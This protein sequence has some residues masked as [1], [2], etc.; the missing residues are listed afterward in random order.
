MAAFF[1]HKTMKLLRTTVLTLILYGLVYAQS[2]RPRLVLTANDARLIRENAGRYPM[3]DR[4]FNDVKAQIEKALAAPIDV[5]VPKDAGGYTHERHKQNYSEMYLAGLL[6]SVTGDERYARFIRDMLKKYADLYPT[7]GEHPARAGESSGRLFWQTLN[8]TVWLVH[9]SQAYDF[10][11]NWLKPEER[12]LFEKNIFRPMAKFFTVDRA[13]EHD[14]IHNHG[15]WMVTAVGMAG[16]AMRDQNLVDIALYGT[17]K[18]GSGGFLKQ[19]DVL[20]S[21]DGYY[22]EGLYYFRYAIMPFILFA[23]AIENNQPDLKIFER[24]GAILKKALYAG[25]QFTNMNGA[26][27]PVNDAMKEKTYRSPE[28]V[29]ALDIMYQRY[30]QDPSLL[31][32]AEKQGGVALLGAG[33]L[34]ARALAET[35]NLIPFPYRS[36]EYSDGASGNEGGIAALR[37]GPESDQLV[38]CMKYTGHGLSHGHYDKLSMLMYDCGNEILQDYGAARFMNVESKY[39]GRYLPETKSFAMQTIAHNT[40]T[41]DE[42]SHFQGKQSVSERFHG[43]KH[44]FS[45]DDPG[46]HIVSAKVDNTYPGVRM[47]RTMAL[48]SDA[49][50]VKPVVIDLFRINAD[51]EHQYDLPF[52]YMGQFLYSTVKYK[53]YDKERVALGSSNGYQHLWKEAEGKADGPVKFSWLNGNRYYTVTSSYDSAMNIIF[54]RIGAGDPNFDLRSEGGMI[55][56]T[57][58]Q[59]YTYA[60]VIEPHGLWDGNAEISRDAYGGVQSVTV[61]A[62]NDEGTVAEILW[63]SGRVWRLMVANGDASTTATHAVFAGGTTYSWIGNAKIERN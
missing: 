3:F 52:Y 2:D 49:D 16:Y 7:L 36:V 26:F 45:A 61:L 18:D 8:E 41:V 9:A 63:K 43:E 39:G 47:Q 20:F 19:M 55:L 24:R 50:N 17:R 33:V 28:V 58:A 42:A 59:N 44:F 48:V 25:L 12:T 31:S 51:K 6:Y 14:R 1:L 56:R 30:G 54:A 11:Y 27:F 29:L 21:P 22:T 15:T 5:P 4:T 32:I 38:V 57:R 53:A 46:F 34:V 35:K 13:N 62:S 10:I 37:M 40:V 60:S 23:Q